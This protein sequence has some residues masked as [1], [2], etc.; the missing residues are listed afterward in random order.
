MPTSQSYFK[1][2]GG[3]FTKLC[4]TLVTPWTITHQAP[5][6]MGFPRQEYCSELPFPSPGDLLDPEIEP[7]SPAFSGIFFTTV[8][9]YCIIYLK[10]V[11]KV[12][13]KCS[14]HTKEMI[15]I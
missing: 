10:V 11:K 9:Q 14:H 8:P 2:C 6:S 1:D 7:V 15:I 13:F 5:L 4:L 12:D 3:D